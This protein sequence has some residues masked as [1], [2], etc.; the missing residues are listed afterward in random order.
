MIFQ[1]ARSFLQ[2]LLGCVTPFVLL[3]GCQTAPPPQAATRGE[4]SVNVVVKAAQD[5]SGAF[6]YAYAGEFFDEKGNFDFSKEGALY[7]KV[8]IQ[9]TIDP[10]SAEGVKFKSDGREAMW[11]IEKI[12]AGPDGSPERPYQGKQFY[13]FSTSADGRTL[14]VTDANDDGVLYRYGL[15]FDYNGGTVADDPDGQNGGGHG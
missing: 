2:F 15:R 11:I 5:A 7:N 6:T 12:N 10:A 1:K 4:V 9:F 13:D 3:A 8:H 14:S